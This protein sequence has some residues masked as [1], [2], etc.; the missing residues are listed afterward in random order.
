MYRQRHREVLADGTR[1][2]GLTVSRVRELIHEG[3]KDPRVITLARR[4]VGPVPEMNTDGEISA[5]F[6][7]VR[8]GVRYTQD[9]FRAETLTD[10][11]TLVQEMTENGLAY[12]DCDDHVV[13][14]GAMLEAV[15]YE[16]EPVIESYRR[17]KS[18]SHIALRVRNEGRTIHLDPTVKD[19]PMG[20]HAGRPS[21]TY[22]EKELTMLVSPAA[23]G[24]P[25]MLGEGGTAETMTGQN[26]DDAWGQFVS[27]FTTLGNWAMTTPFVRGYVMDQQID[28]AKQLAKLNK[29]FGRDVYGS[30]YGMPADA[31][32]H[33]IASG[34]KG[35]AAN[36]GNGN[37]GDKG[38]LEEN[39]PLLL[40]VAAIAVV[41]V[42]LLVKR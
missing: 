12:G 25:V 42:V 30:L 34:A 1:G 10:A 2:T 22:S 3:G 7:H 11:P 14:L 31:L 9:P 37:N 19:K 36:T 29:K 39:A 33:Q 18:P 40:G 27:G 41:G 15:G 26:S 38:F 5:I 17:N 20:V 35:A 8:R 23:L 16:V 24:R 6:N 13:V 28:N 4:L 32:A 21:R